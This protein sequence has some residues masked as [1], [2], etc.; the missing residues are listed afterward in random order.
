MGYLNFEEPP[1]SIRGGQKL[2]MSVSVK[3]KSIDR[4]P[5]FPRA[6]VVVNASVQGWLL[7][8]SNA[9]SGR[10][11]DTVVEEQ[12]TVEAAVQ[13]N[14]TEWMDAIAVS[15]DATVMVSHPAY[16][17]IVALGQDAVPVILR[18]L[19]KKPNLL[20]WALFEITKANPVQPKDYGKIDKITRAWLKWGRKNKYI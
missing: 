1:P 12:L 10:T 15:S 18:S 11:V 3:F 14:F 7:V 4:S 13:K 20:A 8:G 19:Q 16:K 6:R 9:P 17:R 5:T 2:E